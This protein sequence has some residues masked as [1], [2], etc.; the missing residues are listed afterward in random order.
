MLSEAPEILHGLWYGEATLNNGMEQLWITDRKSDGNFRTD[1]RFYKDQQL[2]FTAA[3][4]GKWGANEKYLDVSTLEAFEN[5]IAVPVRKGLELIRYTI[6]KLSKEEL[7]YSLEDNGSNFIV[8]KVTE[9]PPVFDPD[10]QDLKEGQYYLSSASGIHQ[11]TLDNN[12]TLRVI[13]IGQARIDGQIGVYVAYES[14]LNFDQTIVLEEQMV[15]VVKALD[16]YIK[17][18]GLEY[19]FLEAREP[20]KDK[21]TNKYRSYRAG[22]KKTTGNWQKL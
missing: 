19:C 18:T 21:I 2:L 6:T 11:I 10:G 5:G 8:R 16:A 12:E 22:Y 15:A 20:K 14:R 1:Y 3:V 9:R 7:R 13:G 17:T 4:F